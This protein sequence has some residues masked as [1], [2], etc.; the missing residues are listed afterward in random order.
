VTTLS[1][2]RV[3]AERDLGQYWRLG[4]FVAAFS[5]RAARHA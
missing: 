3:R 5:I 2:T 4:V 1:A